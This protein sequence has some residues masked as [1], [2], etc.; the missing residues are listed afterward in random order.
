[1]P[2]LIEIA[3]GNIKDTRHLRYQH[4]LYSY[5]STDFYD[6]LNEMTKYYRISF[7]EFIRD[8]LWRNGIIVDRGEHRIGS[9]VRGKIKDFL[10]MSPMPVHEPPIKN[11]KMKDRQIAGL[12]TLMECGEKNGYFIIVYEE[13]KAL[14][15]MDVCNTGIVVFGGRSWAYVYQGKNYFALTENLP[16]LG[17]FQLAGN[18]V[19]GKLEEAFNGRMKDRTDKLSARRKDYVM[20]QK[21][22]WANYNSQKKKNSES[23]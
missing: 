11:Q 16:L 21:N 13:G 22:G 9:G 7:A 14:M 6:K 10:E 19:I 15:M 18:N 8:D 17:Y 1:M 20:R 4:F 3:K 23:I 12:K 5:P 2:T